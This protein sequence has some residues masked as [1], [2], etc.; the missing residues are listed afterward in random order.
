VNLLVLRGG[1]TLLR[2]PIPSSQTLLN[3]FAPAVSERHVSLGATWKTTATA[4]LTASFMH[5]F[6]NTVNGSGSIPAGFP[7]GGVGGGEADLRMKQRAIGIEW[8]WRY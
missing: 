6:K 5:G 3:V 4:E 1:V 8:A 7:P 2:Q